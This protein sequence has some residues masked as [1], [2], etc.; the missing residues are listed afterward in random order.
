[1]RPKV[2]TQQGDATATIIGKEKGEGANRCGE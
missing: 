2:A 1:M